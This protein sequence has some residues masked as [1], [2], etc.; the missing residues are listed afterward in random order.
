MK[1]LDIDAAFWGIPRGGS[2]HR[3]LEGVLREGQANRPGADVYM[4][5]N[6]IVLGRQIGFL[7]DPAF[8]AAVAAA[9][10]RGP[11][12]RSTLMRLDLQRKFLQLA[13]A[14]PGVYV[15]CGCGGGAATDIVLRAAGW[16]RAAILQWTGYLGVPLIEAL[17]AK[18]A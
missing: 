3:L 12:D 10:V 11:V 9:A 16:D 4:A 13:R 1:P 17:L 6:M 8:G 15:D 2:I 18:A 7:S 14:I 5:D